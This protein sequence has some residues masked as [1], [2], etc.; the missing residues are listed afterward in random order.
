MLSKDELNS[1]LNT[2]DFIETN[3]PNGNVRNIAEFERNQ[4]VIVANQ[5]YQNIN[6]FGFPDS[7]IAE[8]SE[9]A[10]VY[11]LVDGINTNDLADELSDLDNINM[12]NIVFIDAALK[13]IPQNKFYQNQFNHMF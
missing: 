8:M 3:A 1:K 2:K 7:M 12:D 11:I 13:D 6:Y 5:T 4:G 9:E 10:K